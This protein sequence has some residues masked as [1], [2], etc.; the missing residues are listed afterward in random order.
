MFAARMDSFLNLC[1]LLL[2]SSL[3]SLSSGMFG[4]LLSTPSFFSPF[5]KTAF[6]GIHLN[7]IALLCISPLIPFNEMNPR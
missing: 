5:R 3:I 6:I 7:M 1:G 4:D 2:F